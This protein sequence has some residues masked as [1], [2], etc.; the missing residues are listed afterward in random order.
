[1]FNEYRLCTSGYSGKEKRCE[2]LNEERN[3][4]KKVQLGKI[5]QQPVTD[6]NR[7]HRQIL[8]MKKLTNLQK[9]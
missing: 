3:S 2:F 5:T 8:W 4:L 9:I 7:T 6:S 1:M